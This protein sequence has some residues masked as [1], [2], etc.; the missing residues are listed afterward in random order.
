[1]ATKPTFM[2]IMGKTFADEIDARIAAGQSPAQVIDYM[3]DARGM[4]LDRPRSNAIMALSQRKRVTSRMTVQP[5][6]HETADRTSPALS[7]VFETLHR[8]EEHELPLVD[9]ELARMRQLNKTVKSELSLT[10]ALRIIKEHGYIETFNQEVRN[11]LYG[12]NRRG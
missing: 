6:L 4:L 12:G 2:E 3:V 7:D 8:L 9:K 5:V 11:G 1:M 10:V